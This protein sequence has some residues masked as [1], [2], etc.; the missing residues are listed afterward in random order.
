MEKN[1]IRLT[2]SQLHR[3]IKESVK[4]VLREANGSF[5]DEEDSNGNYGEPGMVKS[6]DTGYITLD[7]A[8]IDAKENGYEDVGEYLKYWFDETYPHEFTWQR[9]G[10]G[11]G[12]HGDTL[13]RE[14]GLVIKE[15]Y[16][17]VMFDEEEN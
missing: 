1:R 3:V 7:Q 10:G 11:Y 8:K 17:Q 15:I 6:Y 14:G 16:G 2:E 12:Y 4:R 5:Y 9:L 13:Y